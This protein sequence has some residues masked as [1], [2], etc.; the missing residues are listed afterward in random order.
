[1]REF[2]RI[3]VEQAGH[4]RGLISNLPDTGRIESGT[5]SVAPEPSEV[6]ALAERARNTFLSSGGR[7]AVLVDLPAGLPPMM[8]DRR[9]VV[10]VLNTSSPTPRGTRPSRPRSGSRRCATRRTSR[11]RSPTRDGAWRRTGCPI[12]SAGAP[13]QAGGRRRATGLGLAIFRGSWRRTAAAS[14][15]SAPVTPE[16]G[17]PPRILVVDDDPGHCA[18]SATRSPAPATPRS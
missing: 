4:M 11:S 3:I 12:S 2:H 10:Q 16:P 8:A 6:A 5:L 14:G 13:A 7:H 15:P 1:M 17:G 18:S 9:R